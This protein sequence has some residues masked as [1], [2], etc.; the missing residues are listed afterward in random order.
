MAITKTKTL[1]EASVLY[2]NGL[3]D[4]T[5]VVRYK[6]EVDDPNDNDLP[7]VTTERKHLNRYIVDED[8][9]TEMDVSGEDQKIQDLAGL[10][11]P[12]E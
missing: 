9:Q 12:A 10:L 7:M 5:I 2:D 8:G 1:A 6:I 4:P 3:D 11:W